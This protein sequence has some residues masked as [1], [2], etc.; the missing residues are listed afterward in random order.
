MTLNKLTL[1]DKKIFLPYL[2]L[3]RHELC[4]FSFENIYIWKSLF[5]IRWQF[6][7]DNLCLFFQDKL[8]CFLYLAP[9]GKKINPEATLGAFSIMDKFNRNKEISRIENVEE[10][11]AVFYQQQGSGQAPFF[12]IQYRK[13][14]P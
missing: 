14:K 9:L 4:V 7:G 3:S 5:D 2:N 8:G 10:K 11:N 6:I 1:K 13:I 12:Q